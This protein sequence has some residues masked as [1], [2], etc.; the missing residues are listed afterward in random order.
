MSSTQFRKVGSATEITPVFEIEIQRIK[1]PAVFTDIPESARK[2]GRISGRP[3]INTE[4][5]SRS[6]NRIEH[7]KWTRKFATSLDPNLRPKFVLH[8]DERTLIQGD[9]PWHLVDREGEALASGYSHN[10]QL[11]ISPESGIFIYSDDS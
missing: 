11:S 6:G 10:S 5:N 1:A 3:F 8:A 7:G 4:R 2:A 9:G